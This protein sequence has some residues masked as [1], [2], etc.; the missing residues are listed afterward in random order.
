M[1]PSLDPPPG[2]PTVGVLF[3]RRHG[4]SLNVQVLLDV[5]DSED[6]VV[7]IHLSIPNS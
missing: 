7:S 2:P 6:N 5:D 1:V 4:I 3:V